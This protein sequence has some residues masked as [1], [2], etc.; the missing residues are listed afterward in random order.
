MHAVVFGTAYRGTVMSTYLANYNDDDY[1][2]C[3]QY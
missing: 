1:Y 3:S 2:F